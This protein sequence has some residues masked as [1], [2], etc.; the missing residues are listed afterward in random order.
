MYRI[1][2]GVHL[3]SAA[4]TPSHTKPDFSHRVQTAERMRCSELHT[5]STERESAAADPA[6][7]ALFRGR[8]Q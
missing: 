7:C 4:I 6:N 2:L 1:A 3:K 5:S 8:E